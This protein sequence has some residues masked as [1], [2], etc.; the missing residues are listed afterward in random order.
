[1]RIVLLW[2]AL[3]FASCDRS[4]GA[5]V[6]RDPPPTP[7]AEVPSPA[8]A[9]SWIVAG[10]SH[11]EDVHGWLARLRSH[12]VAGDREAVADAVQFPLSNPP[13]ADR[14]AF[15]ERYEAIVTPSV[16]RALVEQ[17]LHE[18]WRNYQGAMVGD[19]Q[20]WF[21]EVTADEGPPRFAIV[22][23]NS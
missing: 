11:P 17:D 14:A 16:V 19:G 23:I 21:R 6:P 7:V 2:V 20:V 8:G 4:P 18:V 9:T 13:V 15:L 12:V 10:F 1:M 5:P 3:V 22:A